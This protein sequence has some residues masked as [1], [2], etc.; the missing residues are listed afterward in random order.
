MTLTHSCHTCYRHKFLINRS[1]H[2]GSLK[3]TLHST[4]ITMSD[5]LWAIETAFELINTPNERWQDD[6]SLHSSTGNTRHT[7]KPSMPRHRQ[8]TTDVIFDPVVPGDF[9]TNA[10]DMH[11]STEVMYR[12]FAPDLTTI[13]SENLPRLD[14]AYAVQSRDYIAQ[15][16]VTLTLAARN[17]NHHIAGNA[18][19]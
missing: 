5:G 6:V 19:A 9:L 11:Q 16:N 2:R 18:F 15:Q 3:S 13:L 1:A 8:G 14:E 10:I 7:R 12:E 4:A 17:I